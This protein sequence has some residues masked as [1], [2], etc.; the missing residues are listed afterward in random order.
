MRGEGTE[1]GLCAGLH[2]RLP[3]DAQ[4]VAPSAEPGPEL[5]SPRETSEG[6]H[7]DWK[8]FLGR[9]GGH[10]DARLGVWG[11]ERGTQPL[12]CI[13]LPGDAALGSKYLPAP[14]RHRNEDGDGL[15]KSRG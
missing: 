11:W 5:C 13:L 4:S 6:F 1:A 3:G 9:P 15:S 12:H 10:P 7:G 8:W 14:P 2:S